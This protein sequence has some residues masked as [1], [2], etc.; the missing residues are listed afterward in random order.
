MISAGVVPNE[1]LEADLGRAKA[2]EP[3]RQSA[4]ASTKRPV[5]AA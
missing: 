5:A 4:A 2:H 1:A 3:D